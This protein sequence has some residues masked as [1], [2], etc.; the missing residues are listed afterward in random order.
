MSERTWNVRAV[1]TGA[2]VVLVTAVNAPAQTATVMG[3]A[4]TGLI[5]HQVRRRR[6]DRFTRTY[7]RPTEEALQ[8]AFPG[9]RID[10]HVSRDMGNL[11]PRLLRDASPME[12]ALRRWYGARVEPLVTW[13]GEQARRARVRA[14]DPWMQPALDYVRRPRRAGGPSIRLT[15]HDPYLNPDQR[16]TVAGI[17]ASKIPVADTIAQWDTVGS[18]YRV[19][20]T[21]R[22]RPPRKVALKDVADAINKAAEPEYVLGLGAGDKVVSVSLDTDSPHILISARSMSGKSVTVGLIAAQALRKGARVILLDPKGSH[23]ALV[24]LPGVDYCITAAQAHDALVKAAP[25]A[26]ER[27]LLSFHQGLTEWEGQRVWVVVEEIN[28]LMAKLKDYWNEIREKSDPK[29][30]PA[31]SAFRSLSFAGR[32]AKYNMLIVG[33]YVTANAS[34]GPEA[35][36]NAGARLIGRPTQNM[37]KTLCGGTPMPNISSIPGRWYVVVDGDVTEVQIARLHKHELIKLA[38]VL[39]SAD[40]HRPRGQAANP[41][42]LTLREAI[43]TGLI[44]SELGAVQKRLQRSSCRPTPIGKRNGNTDVYRR[45]DLADWAKSESLS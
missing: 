28:I 32:S 12:L 30:S 25:D 45:A 13:P 31:I 1:G 4:T 15:I 7:I 38:T 39:D 17:I 33:Q 3:L 40:Q 36:E 27:N 41:D 19:Q 22:K 23:P 43:D 16:S 8:R 35:R 10:L 20:W 24:G 5:V 44:K 34:A 9:V 37:W 29:L 26:E 18:A 14:V 2:A 42:E 6:G 11:A 21:L